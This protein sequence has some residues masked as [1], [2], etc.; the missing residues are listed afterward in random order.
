MAESIGHRGDAVYEGEPADRR[1]G[2]Y[3]RDEPVH[4]G[5]GRGGGGGHRGGAGHG[6]GD[7]MRGGKRFFWIL[8]IVAIILAIWGVISRVRGRDK[9]GEETAN[10]AIPVVRVAKPT[11][12]PESDE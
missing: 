3:E 11:P 2:P 12:S 1:G 4:G 7:S 9:V 5:R 8:L 6:G 10:E